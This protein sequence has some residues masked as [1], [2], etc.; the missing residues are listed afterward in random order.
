M[1]LFIKV[2]I[3]MSAQLLFLAEIWNLEKL[4]VNVLYVYYSWQLQ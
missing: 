3:N 4:E 1:H 2:K